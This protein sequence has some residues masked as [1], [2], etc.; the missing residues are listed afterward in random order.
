MRQIKKQCDKL[1]GG[2]SVS[3]AVLDVD[4]VKA[5][6]MSLPRCDHTDTTQ[7]VTASH[8][9]QVTRLELDEVDDLARR[10]VVADGVV[11]LDLRIRV[12]DGTAVVCHQE[13]DS[14]WASGHLLHTAQLVL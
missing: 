3:K 12:A 11:G 8:H 2:K 7:I 13:W 14:L 10:D 1:P 9:A 5:T 4:D 6:D